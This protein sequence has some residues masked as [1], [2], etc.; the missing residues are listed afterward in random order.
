LTVPFLFVV[1]GIGGLVCSFD[2]TTTDNPPPESPVSPKKHDKHSN[3][4]GKRTFKQDILLA[5]F[6]AVCVGI[7]SFFGMRYELRQAKQRDMYQAKDQIFKDFVKAN[8]DYR[9]AV[10]EYSFIKLESDMDDFFAELNAAVPKSKVITNTPNMDMV[11]TTFD[12]PRAV[13]ILRKPVSSLEEVTR[14]RTEAAANLKAV[15]YVAKA[16]FG[17]AVR[18]STDGYFK[19]RS[20]PKSTVD[21]RN[22]RKD[23]LAAML[24]GDA[25]QRQ[26]VV[27]RIVSDTVDSIGADPQYQALD[28][29]AEAMGKEIQADQ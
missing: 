13:A 6:T 7:V 1:T 17:D 15:L 20:F 3:D 16:H 29:I 23:M 14:R 10:S 19:S 22:Y 26:T 24:S 27:D 5:L 21:L 4:G 28:N 18:N 11:V 25:D 8:A 2:V 9:A 12:Q